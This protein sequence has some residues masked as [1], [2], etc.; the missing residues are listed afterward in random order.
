MSSVGI[1]AYRSALN[2]GMS[3]DIPDFTSESDRKK[4]E[5]DDASPIPTSNSSNKISP[6]I[7]GLRQPSEEAIKKARAIWEKDGYVEK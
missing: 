3:Y 1:L 6:S 7:K 4:Y 2:D 5:D